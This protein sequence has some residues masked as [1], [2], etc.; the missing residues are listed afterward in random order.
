MNTVW[1]AA[2]ART[3]RETS[4]FTAAGSATIR[5]PSAGDCVGGWGGGGLRARPAGQVTPR[6]DNTNDVTVRTGEACLLI[7]RNEVNWK[8]KNNLQ[9]PKMNSEL[10]A[11]IRNII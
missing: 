8:G 11:E 10:I 6:N 7:H 4:A 9:S 2:A 5:D 3:R 1:K